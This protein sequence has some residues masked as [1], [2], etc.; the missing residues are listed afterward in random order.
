MASCATAPGDERSASQRIAAAAADVVAV[1]L[2]TALETTVGPVLDEIDN[3]V[4]QPVHRGLRD[5]KRNRDA[6]A[7]CLA[8]PQIY[9]GACAEAFPAFHTELPRSP[10]RGSQQTPPA[11]TTG[12]GGAGTAPIAPTGRTTPPV[13]PAAEEGA[14]DPVLNW[15]RLG[16]SLRAH[17]SLKLEPYQDQGGTWHICVG[18]ALQVTEADCEALLAVDM[19]EGARVA[20]RVIGAETW[21]ALTPQRREVLAELAFATNL[22][23]FRK[24]AAAVQAGDW[25][26]AHDEVLDSEWAREIGIAGRPT[27]LA[28]RLRSGAYDQG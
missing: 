15:N 26:A 25:E 9:A 10:A 1:P 2:A 4:V 21:A 14:T 16:A 18:H 3:R 12:A 27:T 28:R 6:R 11:S 19:R 22:P 7:L 8:A 24:L 17:E 23:M 5:R 20:E 13:S